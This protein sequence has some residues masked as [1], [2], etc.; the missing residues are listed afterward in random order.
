MP[1][2]VIETQDTLS[3][4]MLF[5]T[6]SVYEM[7]VSVTALLA[8]HRFTD[9]SRKARKVLG[10]DFYQRLTATMTPYGDGAV[11][12]EFGTGYAQQDD[13]LGFIDFVRRLSPQEFAF[14]MLGRLFPIEEI[15]RVGLSKPA[16]RQ[17]I[18]H[19]PS[20]LDD[21]VC[22]MSLAWL[23]DVPAFQKLVCDLW[24]QYWGDFFHAELEPLRSHWMSGLR[25]KESL[26]QRVGGSS[27]YEHTIGKLELPPNHPPTMPL[28]EIVF[29]PIYFT[30]KR[31]YL[32]FGYGN[33]TILFDS[34]LSASRIE[35]INQARAA[36]LITLKAMGDENRL[37]IL[38]LIVISN[39]TM[40]GKMLAEYLKLSPSAVSRHLAQ[41][42]DGKLI[43][44]KSEDNRT[45]TY[46]LNKEVL[47][48]LPDA[49]MDYL[50]S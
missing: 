43:S 45:I 5:R 13:V 49:I 12:V 36:A 23:D 1:L 31:V 14:Y 41:L 46:T 37:K 38:R 21:W 9:W 24:E 16:I 44:E 48:S 3:E 2:Q 25:E 27:L 11:F 30:V 10:E 7:L 22:Q 33:L 28:R 39:G 4:M 15:Q 32:F 26:L 35:Q 50:Y 19:P 17:L 47:T 20:Y 34:Q 40:S 8:P 29:V 42:K 6:S 18:E